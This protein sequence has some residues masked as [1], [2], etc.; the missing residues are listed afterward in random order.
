MCQCEQTM[1]FLWF[2]DLTFLK[3]HHKD[4]K[5]TENIRLHQTRERGNEHTLQSLGVDK[6]DAQTP[7]QPGRHSGFRRSILRLGRH[8]GLS[9]GVQCNHKGQ[10]QEGQNQ[11]EDLRMGSRNQRGK[12]AWCSWPWRCKKWSKA[13]GCRWRLEARK[14]SVTNLPLEPPGGTSPNDT[15]TLAQWNWLQTADL[16]NYKRKKSVLF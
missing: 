9:R 14:G 6:P 7:W 4:E 15:L 5:C 2:L 1:G 3:V 16:Q 10:R 8:P 13:K 11:R 12:K